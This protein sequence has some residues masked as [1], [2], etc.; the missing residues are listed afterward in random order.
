MNAL[1]EVLRDLERGRF[2]DCPHHDAYLASQNTWLWGVLA[3]LERQQFSGAV[4]V[5][6]RKGKALMFCKIQGGGAVD[7]CPAA[8]LILNVGHT[9]AVCGGTACWW[10]RL[11]SLI[12]NQRSI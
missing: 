12:F 9:P 4:E 5:D 6:F 1:D 2:C 8:P 3:E 11:T 10:I 7:G